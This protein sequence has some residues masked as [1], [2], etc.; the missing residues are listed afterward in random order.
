MGQLKILEYAAHILTGKHPIKISVSSRKGKNQ[1]KTSQIL[2][3]IT[4]QFCDLQLYS[5]T[6]YSE[7]RIADPE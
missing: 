3:V 6:G 1:L 4:R 7:R 5:L 2:L